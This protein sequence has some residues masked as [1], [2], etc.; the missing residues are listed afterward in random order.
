MTSECFRG[1]ELRD[2]RCHFKA[3]AVYN[4]AMLAYTFMLGTKLNTFQ[5]SN[6]PFHTKHHGYYDHYGNCF[7]GANCPRPLQVRLRKP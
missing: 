4:K 2:Q 6:V 7:P 1:G 5:L 3:S